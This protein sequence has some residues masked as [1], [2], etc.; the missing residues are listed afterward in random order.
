MHYLKLQWSHGQHDLV[1]HGFKDGMAFADAALA[2]GEG[3][4]IQCVPSRI[5]PLIVLTI[6]DSSCQCGIS[7]SATMV[8]ALVM[9]AAAQRHSSVPPEVWALPGMQGAYSFVKEKSS[10]V[11]PNMSYVP[12][13]GLINYFH[14]P[15]YSVLFINYWSTRKN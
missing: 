4:L 5:K 13:L 12:F 7:R 3:C 6:Y 14:L 10:H 2:R 8:I 9:R 1:D 11:G 15:N